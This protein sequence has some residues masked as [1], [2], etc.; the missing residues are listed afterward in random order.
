VTRAARRQRPA[1]LRLLALTVAAAA[2]LAVTTPLAPGAAPAGAGP[3]AVA[4]A[5]VAP[6]RTVTVT[7]VPVQDETPQEEQELQEEKLREE[8]RQLRLA[9]DR[10]DSPLGWLLALAPF[11]TA[12][13][14]I[15]TLAAVVFKQQKDS[16]QARAA[17]IVQREKELR[18][19]YDEQFATAMTNVGSDTVGL[20]AAGASALLRL[21]G[22][23]DETLQK[24]LLVY[25]AAQLQ[26]R[27]SPAVLPM[28]REV[29]E[30]AAAEL[31]TPGR[32]EPPLERLTLRDA[33]LTGI[34]LSG[35]DLRRTR[36][37]LS[38]ARLARASLKDTDLWRVKAPEVDL[39]DADC[40]STNF[41]PAVLVGA[42]LRRTRLRGA[43]L[44]S[45][46]LDG[47]DLSGADLRGAS[48]QSAHFRGATMR[49]TKL[50]HAD[51]NDAY[52][53]D[54]VMDEAT[55]QSLAKAKNLDRAHVS[56]RT[57][58]PAGA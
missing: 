30:R 28:L 22:N 41:G 2:L 42:D 3:A 20:Q 14:A 19:R 17:E 25:A 33:D 8:I 1:V 6:A 26:L 24:E 7:P 29:F 10:S 55:R 38:S 43:R 11:L 50:E 57:A 53:V 37:D 46:K 9:N 16:R 15:G 48:L 51:V 39:Q 13:V 21:Q 36:V 49:G 5:G 12:L 45:A 35:L 23:A 52:F 54:V 47:A 4:P 40:T 44:A 27:S 56:L 58:R 31:F 34:G 32:D 18:E